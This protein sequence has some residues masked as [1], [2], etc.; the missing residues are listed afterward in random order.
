MHLHPQE[1]LELQVSAPGGTLLQAVSRHDIQAEIKRT[2]WMVLC[3]ITWVPAFSRAS[4]C[5]SSL[6]EYTLH[7]SARNVQHQP[8]CLP[9]MHTN[10]STK[11]HTWRASTHQEGPYWPET[12]GI[13]RPEA[14]HMILT[15]TQV[16]NATNNCKITSHN[17]RPAKS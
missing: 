15:N 8:I 3:K 10:G 7:G 11:Q 2:S 9:P 12:Q 14:S 17:M 1:P 5:M 4:G 13:D 6:H 16:Q